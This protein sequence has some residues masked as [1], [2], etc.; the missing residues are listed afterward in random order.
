MRALVPTR[1]ATAPRHTW[2]IAYDIVDN[3]RRARVA[4]LL[5]GAGRR[6]QHSVFECRL[7]ERERG[8]LRHRVLS[9]VDLREDQVRWYPLCD[10]CVGRVVAAGQPE[11]PR[12]DEGY[13]IA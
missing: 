12:P 7:T 2:V 13:V 11:G 10:P 5:E 3:R 6:V 4:A 1:P 9:K 8:R